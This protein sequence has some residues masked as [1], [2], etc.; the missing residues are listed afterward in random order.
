MAGIA[1]KFN[2]IYWLY[3]SCIFEAISLDSYP[4]EQQR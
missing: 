1:S 3:L 4:E 2:E